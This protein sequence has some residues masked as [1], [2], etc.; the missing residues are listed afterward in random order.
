MGRRRRKTAP[1]RPTRTIPSIFNCPKCGRA[2]VRVELNRNIGQA[3][4]H[5]SN[6]D[7]QATL[8]ISPL[9]EPVDVYGEFVDI[10]ARSRVTTSKPTN[11][12]LPQEQ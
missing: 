7:V 8:S 11:S 1:R 12:Q 9:T 2:A 6:C 10:C 3:E 4:I 5:C